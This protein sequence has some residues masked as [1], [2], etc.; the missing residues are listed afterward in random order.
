MNKLPIIE[1]ENFLEFQERVPGSA[2]EQ[3]YKLK[4]GSHWSNQHRCE[5]WLIIG[6]SSYKMIDIKQY[7]HLLNSDDIYEIMFEL[8]DLPNY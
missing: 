8:N 2:K 5:Y 4:S 7:F 6:A 3:V 1:V